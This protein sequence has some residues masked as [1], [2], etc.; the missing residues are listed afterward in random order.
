M[1]LFGGPI[2]WCA[3]KQKTIITLI[4]EAELLALS[5]ASKEVYYWSCFFKGIEL[6][7]EH[8]VE[9]LYDNAQ[10]VGLVNKED[11]ELYTKLRHV[12]IHNYWL[13]Q[14]VQQKQL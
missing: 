12:D 11:I 3:R 7:V 8:D 13:C 6:D 5:H 14:E 10:T 9:L 4:T 2:N 1:M